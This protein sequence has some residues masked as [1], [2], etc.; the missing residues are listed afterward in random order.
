MKK[1]ILS[2]TVILAIGMI[3]TGCQKKESLTVIDIDAVSTEVINVAEFRDE[4][5]E[6]DDTVLTNIYTTIQLSDIEKYKVY[7]NSTS[8]KAE[9]LAIFEAKDEAKAENILQAVNERIKDLKF[10]FEGYLPEELQ[11]IENAVVKKE[12]KYVLFA[13]G[14]NYEKI[15][16]VFMKYIK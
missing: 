9:E 8:A 2:L 15:N 11:I 10:G 13:V 16:E 6:L 3:F 7:V 1:S 14:Q 4:L 5:E 12:G